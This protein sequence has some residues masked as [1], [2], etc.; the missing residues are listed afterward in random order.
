MTREMLKSKRRVPRNAIPPI[1]PGPEGSNGNGLVRVQR[2]AR[3]KNF[4][5]ANLHDSQRPGRQRSSQARFFTA[6]S[7][8]KIIQ[9]EL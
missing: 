5:C 4:R 3:L 8:F 9:V 6:S 1:P 2:G 7:H